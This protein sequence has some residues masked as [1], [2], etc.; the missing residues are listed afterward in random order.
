MPCDR[1]LGK[2]KYEKKNTFFIPEVCC[3]LVANAS[4]KFYVIIV[5]QA[6]IKN[7][8]NAMNDYLKKNLKN[9]DGAFKFLK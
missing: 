2:L 9:E 4:K 7:Y 6:M 3:S 1:F 8:E 5:T